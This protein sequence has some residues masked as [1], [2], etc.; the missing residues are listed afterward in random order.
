M[1]ENY[2]IDS[3]SELSSLFVDKTRAAPQA[4]SEQAPSILLFPPLQLAS[5][6]EC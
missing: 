5:V 4:T 3:S 2:Q 6:S 1:L